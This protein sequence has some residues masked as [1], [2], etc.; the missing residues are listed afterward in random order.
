[1]EGGCKDLIHL[2]RRLDSVDDLRRGIIRV[3]VIPRA[4]NRHHRF[5]DG[6]MMLHNHPPH[7]SWAWQAMVHGCSGPLHMR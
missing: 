4:S 2:R 5:R 7:T 6:T 1:M 3:L